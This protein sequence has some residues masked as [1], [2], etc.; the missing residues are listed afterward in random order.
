MNLAPVKSAFWVNVASKKSAFWVNVAKLKSAR[1]VNVAKDGA[2]PPAAQRVATPARV[3]V[4]VG[5]TYDFEFTPPAAGEYV[6]STPVDPKGGV[7]TRRIV[8]RPPQNR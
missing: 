4:D 7:W 5:E 2:D 6:L 8:V 3:A 1:W